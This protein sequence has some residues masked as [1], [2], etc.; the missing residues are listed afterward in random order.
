[1][2]KKMLHRTLLATLSSLALLLST[3]CLFVRVK[4]DE[5]VRHYGSQAV[6]Q[7]PSTTNLS[8]GFPIGATSLVVVWSS[9]DRDVALHACLNYVET[10]SKNKLFNQIGLIVMGPSAKLLAQDE[11]LQAKIELIIAG[12]TKVLAAAESAAAYGVSDKLKGLG[13]EVQPMDKHLADLLKDSGT[14]VLT[15]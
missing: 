10:A 8:L 7:R 4:T 15:F 11:E 6:Q 3:G 14:R 5:Q 9:G 1:L 2:E 13:I 12:G